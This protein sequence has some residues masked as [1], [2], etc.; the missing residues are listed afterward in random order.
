MKR[1]QEC[2]DDERDWENSF[3]GESK[4]EDHDWSKFPHFRFLTRTG[5]VAEILSLILRKYQTSLDKQHDHAHDGVL[6]VLQ[7]RDVSCHSNKMM[8]KKGLE[9]E[10]LSLERDNF[11]CFEDVMTQGYGKH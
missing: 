3:N 9:V 8:D 10:D 5:H 6:F 2:N 1:R 7:D 11:R 4:Q